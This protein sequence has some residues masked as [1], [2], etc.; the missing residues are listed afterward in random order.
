VTL[1]LRKLNG[2]TCLAIVWWVVIFGL[3][4]WWVVR[5]TKREIPWPSDYDTRLV[6]LEGQ[7]ADAK[8]GFNCSDFIS[9]AHGD[10]YIEPAEFYDGAE[11]RLRVVQEVA[12]RSQ[13]DASKL[14][15]GD[16]LA[17]HGVHVAA[18]LGGGRW[19]DADTR[20]GDV[21]EFTLDEKPATDPWFAGK[22]RVLR[23]ITK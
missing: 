14:R 12:D 16:V 21:A 17:V 13:I 8:H 10:D 6:W 4:V 2:R 1:R 22:V 11:G 20:R 19:V 3:L 23:W 7:P 18:Y 9:N 15:P 5:G